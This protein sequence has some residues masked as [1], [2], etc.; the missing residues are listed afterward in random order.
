MG[1]KLAPT[2]SQERIQ[3][4]DILR[5]I[6]ILGILIMNIQ[7]FAMPGAAYLNPLAYGD[8]EGVNYWVWVLSHIFAD[9]KFMSIF[10]ILFGA[11]II[12]VTERAKAKTGKSAGLHYRRNFWL[13]IIG[14]IHAHLIWYGDIL[15]AYA[16]CSLFVY[17]FRNKKPTTLLIVGTLLMS[18]HTL[19]YVFFGYTV[20]MMPQEAYNELLLGWMPTPELINE[21]IAAITGSLPEQIQRVSASA[22]ELELFV[23]FILFMWRAGGLMLVGMALYKW[24]VLSAERS[25]AFY[26]KGAVICF[27]IGFPVIITGV[28]KNFDA[29]WSMDYSMFLG[30]Q[31]NYWGSALVAFGYICL[32]MLF[33]KS[34]QAIWLKRRFAAVGQ[35]ALTNY[36]TQSIIGI[37][38]F[39]GVGFGLFGQVERSIQILLVLAIW[40]AQML[41]SKPW[42]KHFRFGPFEWVWRSLTYWKIQSM[43]KSN[44]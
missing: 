41:W 16:V 39:F 33:C 4:L 35:M 15:V 20:P 14:L 1:N 2:T 32:V 29:G 34:N 11:G 9:Q 37:L 19:I 21:E 25:T 18:V 8:L 24:G 26:I 22:L 13:L 42:L 3:S 44:T 31:F 12:L 27:L 38:I 7:S 10:S 23:F 28:M 40:L 17:L 5:G 43:K 6:A 30:S 36:L